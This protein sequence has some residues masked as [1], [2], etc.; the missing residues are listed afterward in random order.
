LFLRIQLPRIFMLQEGAKGG[1]AMSSC[2]AAAE[3]LDP[4]PRCRV[5]GLADLLFA[6][7]EVQDTYDQDDHHQH[8]GKLGSAIIEMANTV[9]AHAAVCASI[10]RSAS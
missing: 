6:P 10:W 8:R 7:H 9:T 5:T 4:D 3:N 1:P 2:T